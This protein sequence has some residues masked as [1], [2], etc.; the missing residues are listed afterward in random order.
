ML[1][2]GTLHCLRGT[3]LKIA[4]V[5]GARP[6]FIKACVVSR[7]ID[8]LGRQD[9]R[10]ITELLIHTG[11][12]FDVNMSDVFF[13]QLGLREPDHHL[14]ICGGGHGAM[15]GR[16]LGALEE[17]LLE[18][19]PDWVVVFGDTNSTL[20][21]ALAAA[22]LQIPVAHIEAGLRSHNRSMPEEIN[23]VVTDHVSDLLFA[24]TA[25]AV[26]NL[27]KEGI[28]S[29]RISQPGD[30]MYD[31][32]LRFRDNAGAAGDV[33]RRFELDERGYV[34]ATVH[35]A[36]NTDD[37][38]RLRGIFEGLAAIS[39]SQPVLCPL[40][41]RTRQAL[42][43]NG[44]LDAIGQVRLIEPVGYFEMMELERNAAVIITDSGGVQKEAFFHR[45]PCVTVR[46]ETEWVELVEVGANRLVGAD[47][48]AI[49]RGFEQ[50]SASR[51][52]APDLYGKGNAAEAIVRTLLSW[53]AGSNARP[54]LS[55]GLQPAT[56]QSTPAS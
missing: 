46:D 24:P 21:G 55:G 49:V 6:Q 42:A 45:V 35:R 33:L 19:Q 23:R 41:P 13:E 28:P 27:V 5:V 30:V 44:L 36:Q 50:A 1:A 25:T 34:L 17:V 4:T 32:V 18:A 40:H 8:R 51:I 56:A 12:H 11:Q 15:T 9:G 14:G 29:D 38:A 39:R 26:A 7:A 20:A 16:M 47:P 31:V 10:S 48:Q 3:D 53:R 54:G 37:P 2:P 43:R 22:K 52:D